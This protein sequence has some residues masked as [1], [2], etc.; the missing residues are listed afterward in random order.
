MPYDIQQAKCQALHLHW[1][2][3]KSKYILDREWTE[4][5]LNKKDSGLLANEMLNM[6]HLGI[7]TAPVASRILGCIKNSMTSRL[8]EVLLPL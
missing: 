7:L 3:S 8:K 6:T 5:S 1:G 4:G 2:N